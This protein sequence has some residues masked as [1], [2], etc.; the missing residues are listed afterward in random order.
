MSA[1]QAGG[2]RLSFQRRQRTIFVLLTASVCGAPD[3]QLADRSLAT[4]EDK[5]VISE[6]VVIVLFRLLEEYD[7]V[8]GW[9]RTADEEE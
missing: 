9:K 4:S 1:R 7:V 6:I 2:A 5:F 3:E 8:Q